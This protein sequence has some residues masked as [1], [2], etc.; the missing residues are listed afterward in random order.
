MR[1]FFVLVVTVAVPV[2][3]WAD[4][5]KKPDYY[6]LKKGSKWEYEVT[7]TDGKKHDESVEVADVELKDGKIIATVKKSSPGVIGTYVYSADETTILELKW[8]DIKH[9]PPIPRLKFPLKKGENW[10]LKKDDVELTWV[11][12]EHVEVTVPAGK[13]NAIPITYTEAVGTLRVKNTLHYADGVGFIRR[14][15]VF[16]LGT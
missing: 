6:P 14:E 7:M 16:F 5:P 12:G 13:F 4:D 10:S 15:G 2:G 3:S 8:N 9:E 1:V 11:V